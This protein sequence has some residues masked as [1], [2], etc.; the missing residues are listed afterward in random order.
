[1]KKIILAFI[2]SI[3]YTNAQRI[4]IDKN[5]DKNKEPLDKIYDSEKDV[6]LLGFGK[7]IGGLVSGYAVNDINLYSRKNGEETKLLSDK[8]FYYLFFSDD[9]KSFITSDISK[10][11]LRSSTKFV[12]LEGKEIVIEKKLLNGIQVLSLSGDKKIVFNNSTIYNL[13]NKKGELNIDLD[14]DKSLKLNILDMNNSTKKIVELAVPNIERLK[15]ENNIKYKAKIGVNFEIENNDS[16]SLV[17][18]S[19]SKDYKNMSLYKTVYSNDGKFIEDI[20]F[21]IDLKG[22]NLLYSRN[23]G[24]ETTFGGYE[25]KFTHFDDDNSINNHFIDKRNGDVYIYGLFGEDISALNT[26]GNPKGYYVFKFDKNGNKVWESINKINDPDFNKD[27]AMVTVYTNLFELNSN[28]ICFSIK[29]NGLKDYFMYSVLTKDSGTISKFKELSFEQTFAH[30]ESVPGN[31]YKINSDFKDD[32]DFKNKEFNFNSI[33]A[34]NNDKRVLEYIK[35][36]KSDSKTNFY[37]YFSDK[38]TWIY[39]EDKK[40]FRIVLFE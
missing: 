31:E 39:E 35:N 19:I 16:F 7:E 2:L 28:N 23:N 11:I 3:N 1:M 5:I 29:I 21:A 8:K 34:I 4:L 37:T 17:T 13:T 24:G 36:R 38:L 18:K 14:K 33:I 30:L 40:S 9:K 15:N 25:G 22:K 32:K 27:H 12:S 6:F 20:S 10:G 26:Q